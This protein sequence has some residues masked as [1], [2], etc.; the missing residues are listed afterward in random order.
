MYDF[1]YFDLD[2]TLVKDNPITGKS[3]LLNSGLEKYNE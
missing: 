1:I 2:D 3:E